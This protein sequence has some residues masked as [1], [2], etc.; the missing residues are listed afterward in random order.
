MIF[1]YNFFYGEFAN[2][3]PGNQQIGN[4]FQKN[5]N[6]HANDVGKEKIYLNI[7]IVLYLENIAN[8]LQYSL[9]QSYFY[10]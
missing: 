1:G 3:S 9:A 10:K 5:Q 2:S 4:L 8:D 7:T 6:D